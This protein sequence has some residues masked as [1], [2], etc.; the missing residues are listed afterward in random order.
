MAFGAMGL[1]MTLIATAAIAG[2]A[3]KEKSATTSIAAG[4]EGE[5]TAKCKRGSEAVSGGFSLPDF[6]IDYIQGAI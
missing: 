6:D 1:L 2:G 3:L 5:A 4:D